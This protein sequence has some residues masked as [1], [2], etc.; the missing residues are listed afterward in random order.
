MKYVPCF[1][2]STQKQK[3]T[4]I[5]A[6][7]SGL[8]GGDRRNHAALQVSLPARRH[9]RH[10]SLRVCVCVWGLLV[11]IGWRPPVCAVRCASVSPWRASA[12][13]RLTDVARRSGQREKQ[14]SFLSQLF[15]AA[16]PAS[17]LSLSLT[18]GGPGRS[19]R[20]CGTPRLLLARPRC[21]HPTRASH[22]RRV[23]KC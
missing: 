13:S 16:P 4:P 2:F 1:F 22:L 21:M 14:Q 8:A 12:V 9:P 10:F 3:N 19:G 23:V 17:I 6:P 7:S 18:L 5:P 11:R 15:V 20:S